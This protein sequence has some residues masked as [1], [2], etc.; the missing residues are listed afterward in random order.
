LLIFLSVSFEWTICRELVFNSL[1]NYL[2]SPVFQFVI[3]DLKLDGVS[4]ST[5]RASLL[6]NIEYIFVFVI[7][8]TALQNAAGP[9]PL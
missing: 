5:A 4:Y 6:I 7:F 8:G 1:I 9:L 3:F 2:A